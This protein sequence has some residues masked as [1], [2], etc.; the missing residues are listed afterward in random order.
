MP[1]RWP[2]YVSMRTAYSKRTNTYGFVCRPTGPRTYKK[3]P[4]M[5]PQLRPIRAKSLPFPTIAIHRQM[6]SCLQ[7][8]LHSPVTHHPRAIRKPS[9]E[10]DHL[11]I[12]VGPSVARITGCEERPTRTGP[13]R[14]WSLIICLPGSGV[15]PPTFYLRSTHSG[16]PPPCT[17]Q[18]IPPTRDCMTCYLPHWANIFWITIPLADSSY[19]LSPCTTTPLIRMIIY[20]TLTRP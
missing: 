3:L 17:Q 14:S 6:T 2:N 9:P 10:R 5:Y 8:A 7:I 13:I 20:C 4:S 16:R 12:P 1:E 19:R 18:L 15:C 11:A